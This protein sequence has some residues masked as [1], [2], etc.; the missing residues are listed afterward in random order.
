[1]G[2]FSSS[3]TETY[4]TGA[5]RWNQASRCLRQTKRK[6]KRDLWLTLALSSVL[7]LPRLRTRPPSPLL[8]RP[9]SLPLA[10]SRIRALTFWR[11]LPVSPV[12]PTKWERRAKRAGD[13]RVRGWSQGRLPSLTT[14]ARTDP[15]N[16]L[17]S[18]LHPTPPPHLVELLL[19]SLPFLFVSCDLF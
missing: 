14:G 7:C 4:N 11:A 3:G 18:A 19:T 16:Y 5:D 8:S 13:S 15:D 6:R 1:M 12:L 2:L 10:H 17:P 9:V